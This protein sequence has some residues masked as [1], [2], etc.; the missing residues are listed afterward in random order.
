MATLVPG[1]Y[2]IRTFRRLSVFDEYHY[3]YAVNAKP[4]GY[5]DLDDTEYNNGGGRKSNPR[6]SIG[7]ISEHLDRRL[8]STSTT[9]RESA[10]AAAV[11]PLTPTGPPLRLEQ[12]GRTASYY[13]HQ[14]DTQFDDY[15]AARASLSLKSDIERAMAAEFG[16]S[17]SSPGA[18]KE[19]DLAR[20][21][22]VIGAGTVASGRVD[23]VGRTPSSGS[24]PWDNGSRQLTAVPELLE[25]A[26]E[27]DI[28]HGQP[29]DAPAGVGPDGH[30]DEDRQALLHGHERTYSQ[31]GVIVMESEADLGQRKRKWTN[32]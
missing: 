10:S 9:R 28:G 21:P 24:S 12:I 22:S 31:E 2:A 3:G 20:R 6:L 8:S 32:G 23:L 7:A 13:S 17:S 29:I 15:V 14:R 19:D 25:E 4:Y 1:I 16:W 30:G 5:G 18:G 26:D 11:S 27:Q